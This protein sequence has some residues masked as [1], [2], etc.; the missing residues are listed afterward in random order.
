ME[1]RQTET[2]TEPCPCISGTWHLS[3]PGHY[4]FTYTITPSQMPPA[5]GE[6]DVTS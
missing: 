1:A 2:V 5:T 3:A 6:F 4:L